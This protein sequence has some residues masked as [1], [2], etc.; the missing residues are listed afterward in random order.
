MV[1]VYVFIMCIYIDI[2]VYNLKIFINNKDVRVLYIFYM[3]IIIFRD[4]KI[5]LFYYSF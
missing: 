4:L 5:F 3:C 2:F 1:F